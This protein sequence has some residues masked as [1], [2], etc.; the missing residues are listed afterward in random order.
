[1][2]RK[3]RQRGMDLAARV[4]RAGWGDRRRGAAPFDTWTSTSAPD[5]QISFGERAAAEDR[6]ARLSRNFEGKLTPGLININTAPIEVLRAMPQML[7]LVYD[8]DFPIV[9]TSDSNPTQLNVATSE[10]GRRRTLRSAGLWELAPYDLGG[11][12]PGPANPGSIL[13]DY[14]V[15]APRVRAAEAM[16]LWRNKGNVTPDLA[17]NL[18]TNMPSYFSRGLDFPDASNYREWAPDT[19]SERGFDSLGELALLTK[20]AEFTPSATAD[21]NGNGTPDVIDIMLRR[22]ND[23]N[24]NNIDDAGD[25]AQLPDRVIRLA[26]L[27]EQSR[28]PENFFW[29]DLK[30][31]GDLLNFKSLAQNFESR[32]LLP[33]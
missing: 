9:R 24:R 11:G 16:E 27:L 14:G 28:K 3:A 10:L 15:T 4:R 22:A 26:E 30:Q 23:A 8:D 19:R 17:N 5:G 13:F 20:G 2:V 25:L 12:N 32:H 33:E 21:G 7:R 1:M 31:S 18:F 6:R 29:L